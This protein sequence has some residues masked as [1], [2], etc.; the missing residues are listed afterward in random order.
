MTRIARLAL[1][2]SLSLLPF[3]LVQAQPPTTEEE[4]RQRLEYH[5]RQQPERCAEITARHSQRQARIAAWCNQ[6][7]DECARRKAQWQEQRA[8]REVWCAQN[9]G[10]C[11]Y[12]PPGRQWRRGAW[13][14]GWPGN[15]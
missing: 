13:R 14:R 7:P 2:L 12:G 11:A 6:Y 5:C 1:I 8:R 10:A 3:Q 9:P 4:A 15:P